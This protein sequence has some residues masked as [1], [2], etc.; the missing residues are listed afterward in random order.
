[1]WVEHLSGRDHLLAA[2]RGPNQ[3]FGRP[4]VIAGSGY[5]SSPA[6]SWSEGGDLLVAYQ[7]SISRRGRSTQRRVEARVRRAGHN[8]GRPQ[9]LG[10]SSGFSQIT[11]ATAPSRR[12]LVAWGTQDLG[13]EANTPWIVRAAQR[14]AGAGAFRPAQ[15]L[16]RSEGIE[17]PAGRVAAALAP[18]GTAT[19]AWSGIAGRFGSSFPARVATA[20][21]S[22]R[23]GAPQTLSSSAAVGDVTSDDQGQTLVVWATLEQAGDSQSSAQVFASVRAAGAPAFATPEQ[24]SPIEGATLPRAAFDP[25]THRPAAV[26]ISRT[27]NTTQVLRFAT[28]GG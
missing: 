16:E 23:F 13:E 19:V 10:S 18:D 17:R 25:R 6:L 11:A 26:W 20:G 9:Q 14:P 22:L 15:E 5:I 2:L 3:L 8:W 7:R 28:R 4:G 24:V 12:M 21:S 1:V 27:S